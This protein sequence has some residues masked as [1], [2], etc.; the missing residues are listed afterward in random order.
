MDTVWWFKIIGYSVVL[1]IVV[2][3]FKT[4]IKKSNID[5]TQGEISIYHR[6]LY[7]VA[8]TCFMAGIISVLFE[9]LLEIP[10]VCY[11][12]YP[13]ALGWTISIRANI[14]LIKL[15][16]YNTYFQIHKCIQNIRLSK[17][18][19]YCFIFNLCCVYY[20][21]MDFSLIIPST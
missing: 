4:E 15:L 21:N 18:D 20:S 14:T 1:L 16:D 9:I 10:Y 8:M 11:P 12:A 6:S 17:M 2:S 3:I 19:I 7:Y 5:K 13:L